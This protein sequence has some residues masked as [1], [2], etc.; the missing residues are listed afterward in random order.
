MKIDTN[1]ASNLK[2]DEFAEKSTH[3]GTTV[4]PTLISDRFTQ[5]KNSPKSKNLNL[6]GN[7]PSKFAKSGEENT[8]NP[9]K[10]NKN[11]QETNG[12]YT[13]SRQNEGYK[14]N[15]E[16]QE[17]EE[18]IPA[19]NNTNGVNKGSGAKVGF[20]GLVGQSYGNFFCQISILKT[21]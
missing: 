12:N 2:Q 5:S 21:N 1:W 13:D 4:A 11:M 6:A 17:E 14:S 18:G 10:D 3:C 8:K 19:E 7:D 16:E 9:P 20:N 15:V